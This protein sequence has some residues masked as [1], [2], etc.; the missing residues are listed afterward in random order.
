MAT[1]ELAA[2]AGAIFTVEDLTEE[3]ENQ[4]D[5]SRYW[6]PSYVTKS[7]WRNWWKADSC[8]PRQIALGGH[9]TTNKSLHH[10]AMSG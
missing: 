3:E 4:A 2:D 7:T 5:R 9:Q 8:P 10:K 6:L 1:A